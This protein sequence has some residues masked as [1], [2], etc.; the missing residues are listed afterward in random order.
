MAFKF[1]IDSQLVDSPIDDTT[2]LQTTISRSQDL[3]TVL[4]TQD[5]EL[6]W[7][8]NNQLNAGEISGYAYLKNLFV[9]QICA[10]AEIKIYDQVSS[11]VTV[12]IHT[13]IIKIP[14]LSIQL[15]QL[16]LTIKVQD[17]SYY[18]YIKNNQNIKVNFAGFTTKNRTAITP[19]TPYSID[20][21][22][23]VTGD[24]LSTQGKRFRGFRLLEVFE[25][26]VAAITDN[27]VSFQSTLLSTEPEIFIFKGQ[28]LLNPYTLFPNAPDPVFELSFA[29]LLSEVSK[30]KNVKLFIDA[31]DP[32]N[33]VLN[34]ENDKTSFAPSFVH[35]FADIKDLKVSIL[36][37]N[38]YG[39]VKVGSTNTIDGQASWLDDWNEATS[40]YGWKLEEFFPLGQCN[41]DVELNL[42]SNFN[43]SHNIIMDI[44]IGGSTSTIDDYFFIECRNLDHGLREG[45]A[46]RYGFFGQPQ[47][48]LFYNFGLNNFQKLQAHAD[49]FETQFGNFF[50]L[51]QDTFKALL[52]DSPAQD[53]T[54]VT[55][56][57]SSPFFI[58]P[59]T[60][61]TI[62]PGEF[63]NE[64]TNGGYD[65]NGNYNN[66]S[67]EY[68]VP[69]DGDYSFHSHFDLEIQGM[70]GSEQFLFDLHIQALDAGLNVIASNTTNSFPGFTGNGLRELDT[71]LVAQL[72]AGDTV[73]C[74]YNVRFIPNQ[75]GNFQVPRNFTVIWSSYFECNGTPDGSSSI[76]SGN[77]DVKKYLYEFEDALSQTQ[78]LALKSNPTGY[79]TFEKDGITRIGWIHSIQMNDFKGTN[80]I[81]KL[82]SSDAPST[83]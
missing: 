28:S 80:T 30:I 68:T 43:L 10:E 53:V 65:G 37:Q 75:A 82:L 16:N 77:K 46:R 48:P 54:Y 59:V 72:S 74:F 58:P 20:L 2:A 29:E 50:G 25:F 13:G 6:S 23:G 63:V 32:D 49:L 7:N 78:M 79:C 41:I 35:H 40:Y 67:F 44:L 27:K 24:F 12:L 71:T 34:L 4:V 45:F 47:P 17:N 73:R 69:A 14:S 9:N 42:V 26:M 19:L 31:S 52:G 56:P 62:D 22:D 36:N 60:G 18:A 66:V 21:F 39:N 57:G 8:A 83:Q 61:I 1:Y 5:A 64:T 55:A 70:Q 15:H 11:S 33:P 81:V 76:T 51:G 3:G 38:L